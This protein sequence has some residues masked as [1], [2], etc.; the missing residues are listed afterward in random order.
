[1]SKDEFTSIVE[2][3]FLL[4]PERFRERV[5]NVAVLVEDEPSQEVRKQEGLEAGETLLGLYHGI[6]ATERGDTYGVGPTLPDTITLFQKPIEA[7]AGGSIQKMRKIVA[8]TV[9]HECAHYFG[10]E[11]EEVRAREALRNTPD[12]SD[13]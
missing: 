3:A 8:D 1:M 6:P 13:S 11:E 9:W 12:E 5:R 7:L 10:M 2:K 4:I